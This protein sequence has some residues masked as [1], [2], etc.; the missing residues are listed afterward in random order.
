MGAMDLTLPEDVV[1]DIERL[2]FENDLTFEQQADT[3]LRWAIGNFPRRENE[4]PRMERL[5]ASTPGGSFRN[6]V[7][8]PRWKLP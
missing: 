4:R 3:L 5:A 6:A 7:N 2:A 8:P 1:A